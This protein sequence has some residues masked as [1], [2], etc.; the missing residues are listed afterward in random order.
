MTAKMTVDSLQLIWSSGYSLLLVPKHG[1]SKR[2]W[3]S[4]RITNTFAV[5]ERE[6]MSAI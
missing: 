5:I 2:G 3:A 1:H 4:E 6:L